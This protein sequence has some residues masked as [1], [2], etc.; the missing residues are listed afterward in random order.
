MFGIVI[1]AVPLELALFVVALALGAGALLWWDG[2]RTVAPTTAARR[3]VRHATT[4]MGVAL[5]PGVAG[6]LLPVLSFHLGI[7]PH[8]KTAEL[9]VVPTLGLWV[10]LAVYA[11][12]EL[13]WP[14]PRDTH[15]QARLTTRTT[16][17]VA[18]RGA[19]R[20]AWITAAVLVVTT[21]LLALVA[22]GPDSIARVMDGVLE[23]QTLFPGWAWT[24]PVLLA[25][26][27]ALA[28]TEA[29]LY[30]IAVRPAVADVDE[31]WDMWLRRRGARRV[32][33][34]VQLVVGLSL[35]V[36]VGGAGI[37]LRMLGLGRTTMS[38][39]ALPVVPEYVTLANVVLWVAVAVA[40]TAVV[41]AC[42]RTRDPL[43]DTASG[44]PAVGARS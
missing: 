33:R 40:L 9:V 24:G 11:V 2:R 13:T 38:T 17:D 8:V 44:R 25:T 15:R 4:T 23:R 18:D 27:V 37:A 16:A 12:G 21:V 35:A 26:L 20:R 41:T 14:R 34:V 22:D 39:A 5:V 42:W 1:G 10:F 7:G 3:A 31:A 6:V 29:V 43:P 19:R 30:L 28:L 32:L 36:L